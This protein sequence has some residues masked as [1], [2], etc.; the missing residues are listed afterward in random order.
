MLYK[1]TK[2]AALYRGAYKPGKLY[3]GAQLVAGYADVAKAAPASWD[4]TYGDT[5]SV[6][7]TGKGKQEGTPTPAAPVPLVAAECSRPADGRAPH[8]LP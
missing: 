6:T 3:K 7:A 8:R 2:P 5:V 1:G 4:G